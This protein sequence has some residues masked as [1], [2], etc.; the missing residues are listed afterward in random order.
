MLKGTRRLIISSLILAL[1]CACATS[2]VPLPT[3]TSTVAT[4]PLAIMT[5]VSTPFTSTILPTT[6]PAVIPTFAPTD[7]PTPEV[8]ASETPWPTATPLP[9]SPLITHTWQVGPVLI[10]QYIYASSDGGPCLF[11]S[12]RDVPTILYSDG[13]LI[14]G[15]D[16]GAG[17]EIVQGKLSRQQMCAVLNT[18]DQTGFLQLAPQDWYRLETGGPS[19]YIDVQAWITQTISFYEPQFVLEAFKD[20]P[21]TVKKLSVPKVIRDVDSLLTNLSVQNMKPYAPNRLVLFVTSHNPQVWP[22][23]DPQWPLTLKLSTVVS[24]TLVDETQVVPQALEGPQAT[25]LYERYFRQISGDAPV[26][27]VE[28]EFI[29]SVSVLPL[30]PYESFTG[31]AESNPKIPSPDVTYT[32]KTM[33]CQPSDGMVPIP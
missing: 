24:P 14:M 11:C 31:R 3:L 27:F 13:T 30:Y 7:T 12:F 5:S 6:H 9:L 20:E 21:D 33:T 19:M 10:Q 8:T 17:R 16:L 22:P 29:Y 23:F 28:G 4:L 26:D 18:I 25:Q 1:A 32:T 15:R 2:P